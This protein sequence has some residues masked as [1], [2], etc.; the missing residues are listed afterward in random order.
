MGVEA[1]YGVGLKSAQEWGCP[2]SIK[3]LLKVI[4]SALTP[5]LLLLF[6]CVYIKNRFWKLADR[7]KCAQPIEELFPTPPLSLCSGSWGWIE[8]YGV[9]MWDKVS[10]S[11]LRHRVPHTP[12]FSLNTASGLCTLIYINCMKKIN[13]N[14]SPPPLKPNRTNSYLGIALHWPISLTRE[15]QREALALSYL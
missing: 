6:T 10:P 11:Q 7:Y 8:D 15:N 1:S 13:S 12:Y 3:C 9:D 5:S 2:C 14:P 4:R